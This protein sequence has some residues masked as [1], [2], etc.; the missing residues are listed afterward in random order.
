MQVLVMSDMQLKGWLNL[1][2]AMVSTTG[3]LF[4]ASI[5]CLCTYGLWRWLMIQIDREVKRD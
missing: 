3:F 1:T 5:M 2:T 4:L